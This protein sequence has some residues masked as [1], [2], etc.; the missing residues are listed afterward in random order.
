[1]LLIVTGVFW[2]FLKVAVL[3]PLLAPSATL[4][5]DKLAGVNLVCANPGKQRTSSDAAVR[6]ARKLERQLPM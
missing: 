1:M 4:P 2:R 6:S 5:K 3:G